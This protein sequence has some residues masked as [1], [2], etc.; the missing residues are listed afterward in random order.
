MESIYRSE[1]IIPLPLNLP[2][3]TL[4][5]LKNLIV[6]NVLIQCSWVVRT[7]T[8]EISHIIDR[9]WVGLGMARSAI[10]TRQ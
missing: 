9:R 5:E 1:A 8:P 4:H 2:P 10:D 6:G 3:V 7:E